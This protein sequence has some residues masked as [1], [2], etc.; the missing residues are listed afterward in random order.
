MIEKNELLSRLD[1]LYEMIFEEHQSKFMEAIEKRTVIT[2][3]EVQKVLSELAEENDL[4]YFQTSLLKQSNTTRAAIE[5]GLG[6]LKRIWR[7]KKKVSEE[8]TRNKL[9]EFQ[10]RYVYVNGK[11]NKPLQI[12]SSFK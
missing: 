5:E 10:V 7:K 6:N 11:W 1:A 8:E 4:D 3:G 12:S 9:R 2:G